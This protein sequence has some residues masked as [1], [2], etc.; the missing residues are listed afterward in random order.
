MNLITLGPVPWDEECAQLGCENY[1]ELARKECIAFK[2]QIIRFLESNN[3]PKS[4][5]PENFK[6][7][8]SSHPHDF[9]N[10]Y[11]IS[12]KYSDTASEDLAI[13]LE[14]NLPPCWD[15]FAMEELNDSKTHQCS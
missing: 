15:E 14:N 10:Y 6:L 1:T 12:A 7:I 3:H 5:W 11:E 13:F 9:G 2:N 4:S 8:I